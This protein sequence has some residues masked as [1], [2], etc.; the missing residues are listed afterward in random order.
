MVDGLAL[1]FV[2]IDWNCVVCVQ[3]FVQ[4]TGVVQFSSFPELVSACLI[5]VTCKASALSLILYFP[6]SW[7]WWL[8]LTNSVST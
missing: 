7:S 2:L 3:C 6:L 4:E 1:V 8:V 5:V